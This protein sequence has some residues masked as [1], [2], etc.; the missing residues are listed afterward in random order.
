MKHVSVLLIL[1]VLALGASAQ[2]ILN[3]SSTIASMLDLREDQFRSPDKID[4]WRV[5]LLATTERSKVMELKA[6]FLNEYP[7]I[8]ADW[9]YSAPYYKMKVGSYL[10][11]LEAFRLRSRIRV[12]FPD[13][14][15][16]RD[17]VRPRDL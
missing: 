16:I 9:D 13:A 12:N 1:A 10:T 14:Y 6:R 7:N 8:S 15:V 4:G 17:K 5:Q 3:E 11:K 2:I